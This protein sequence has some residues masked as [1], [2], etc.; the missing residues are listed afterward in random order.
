MRQTSACVQLCWDPFLDPGEPAG[1]R[2]NDPA[3]DGWLV[4]CQF[5][6][7]HGG[8]HPDHVLAS[9]TSQ[10]GGQVAINRGGRGGW[11]ASAWTVRV[12]EQV[13]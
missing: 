1:A 11:A 9:M 5:D 6:V 8:V 10:R 12:G 13:T 7:G 3:D 4:R 2:G